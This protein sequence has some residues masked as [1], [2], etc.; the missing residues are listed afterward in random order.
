MKDYSAWI[1]NFTTKGKPE[2][3]E[4]TN[5]QQPR[6]RKEDF[7][8]IID[9]MFS[10]AARDIGFSHLGAVLFVDGDIGYTVEMITRHSGYE[11]RIDADVFVNG[12]YYRTMNIAC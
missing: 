3:L 4:R 5:R 2:I 8:M 7:D 9:T 6:S 10:F 12:R 11:E 1:F